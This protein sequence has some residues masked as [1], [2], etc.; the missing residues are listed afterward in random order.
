MGIKTLINELKINIKFNW[1]FSS[2]VQENRLCWIDLYTFRGRLNN[3][4]EILEEIP[5]KAEMLKDR[6]FRK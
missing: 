1:N 3:M 6:M 4:G 5:G 2:C